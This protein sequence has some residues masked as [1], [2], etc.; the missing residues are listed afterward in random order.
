MKTITGIVI[1]DKMNKTAVVEVTRF[2]AHPLYHKRMRRTKK[3][4]AVNEVGAKVGQKIDLVEIRPIS[5]LTRFRIS[6]IWSN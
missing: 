1:S 5:K 6:K 2:L 3:Y 4:H